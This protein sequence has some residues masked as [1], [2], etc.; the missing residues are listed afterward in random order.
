[1]MPS[2]IRLVGPPWA[3]L[4]RDGGGAAAVAIALFVLVIARSVAARS[5]AVAIE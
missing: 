3:A 5:D 4:V 1:M 2:S